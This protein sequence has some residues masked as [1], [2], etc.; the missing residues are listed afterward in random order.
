M[1]I[2]RDARVNQSRAR[3]YQDTGAALIR[4]QIPKLFLSFTENLRTASLEPF[5]LPRD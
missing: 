1:G 3:R 2:R 4:F 5:G